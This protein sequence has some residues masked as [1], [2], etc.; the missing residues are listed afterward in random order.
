[1]KWHPYRGMAPQAAALPPVP[2]HH[3]LNVEINAL[4]LSLFLCNFVFLVLFVR[5]VLVAVFAHCALSITVMDVIAC[6]IL[7]H[8]SWFASVCCCND[9]VFAVVMNMFYIP[10]CKYEQDFPQGL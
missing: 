1:M 6:L 2:Q 4:T 9:V 5:C 7:G 10:P 3:V 8:S